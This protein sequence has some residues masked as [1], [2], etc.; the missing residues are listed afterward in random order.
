[1]VRLNEIHVGPTVTLGVVDA[2]V[3]IGC[4]LNEEVA[5]AVTVMFDVVPSAVL[6]D[7]RNAAESV[8]AWL[9]TVLRLSLCK[10]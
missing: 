5:T 7:A 6:T 9:T 4:T 3:G 8:V 1:M 2:K 10:E